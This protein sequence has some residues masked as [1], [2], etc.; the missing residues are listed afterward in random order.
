MN[1][2]LSKSQKAR[3][4][5]TCPTYLSKLPKK[6]FTAVKSAHSD[7]DGSV[8]CWP[9]AVH[10][11]L[12]TYATS[13]AIREAVLTLNDDHQKR[14]ED[15]RPYEA[16]LS[17]AAERCVNFHSADKKITSFV[18][19]LNESINTL[20]ARYREEKRHAAYL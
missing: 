6:Q 7:S 9:E 5:F 3:L 20:V 13:G 1:A 16:R 19:R 17:T 2:T 12:R 8:T 11:L 14:D 18:D 4:K 15:E 10:Y